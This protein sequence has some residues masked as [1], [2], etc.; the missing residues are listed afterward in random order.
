M[1]LADAIEEWG[2][3]NRT[4]LDG[5]RA[6][7][8]RRV[9]STIRRSPAAGFDIGAMSRDDSRS[10]MALFEKSEAGEVAAILN[11]V[12]EW[13]LENPDATD[14]LNGAGSGRMSR[15]VQTPSE[16]GANARPR[17]RDNRWVNLAIIGISLVAAVVVIALL[18]VLY[19][20]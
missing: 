6:E 17:R 5:A 2:I 15:L 11:S 7:T 9:W 12:R 4:D 19:V 16:A 10:V 14:R 13:S 18:I 8:V 20:A 1:R 3:E